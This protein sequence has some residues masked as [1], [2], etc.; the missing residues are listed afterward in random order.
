MPKRQP[1]ILHIRFS[2]LNPLWLVFKSTAQR[3]PFRRIHTPPTPPSRLARSGLR[4]R[5]GGSGAR[6]WWQRCSSWSPTTT[7]LCHDLR[8]GLS[9]NRTGAPPQVFLDTSPS[10]GGYWVLRVLGW[11]VHGCWACSFGLTFEDM[12]DVFFF[13]S[14][15]TLGPNRPN[16]GGFRTNHI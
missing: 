2:L 8:R 11:M 15:T 16:I 4:L 3:S 5:A 10:F 7:T 1:P 6:S 14:Y 9:P 12:F 13:T